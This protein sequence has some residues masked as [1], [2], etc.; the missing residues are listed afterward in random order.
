METLKLY[1]P[2]RLGPEGQPYSTRA[3][4]ADHIETSYHWTSASALTARDAYFDAGAKAVTVCGL[5]IT[6]AATGFPR[7]ANL[8]EV[9]D[10]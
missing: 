1:N 8:P 9:K 3:R 6:V 5:P 7:L 4:F 10:E 2:A